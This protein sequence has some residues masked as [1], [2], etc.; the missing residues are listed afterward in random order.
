MP[1][2]SLNI[3]YVFNSQQLLIATYVGEGNSSDFDQYFRNRNLGC[4]LLYNFSKAAKIDERRRNNL[5]ELNQAGNGS[6]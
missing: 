6:S 5:D 3:N 4:T 1:D 2:L